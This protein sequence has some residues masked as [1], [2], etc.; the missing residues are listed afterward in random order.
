MAPEIRAALDRHARRN[1]L[2]VTVCCCCGRLK[3]I[4]RVDP[5]NAGISDGLHESCVREF[6]RRFGGKAVA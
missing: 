2:I 3:S 5:A 4:Q 1:A 6:K